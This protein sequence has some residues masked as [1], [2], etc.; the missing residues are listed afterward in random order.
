MVVVNDFGIGQ[1]SS[2]RRTP[3]GGSKTFI[4][5][6]TQNHALKRAHNLSLEPKVHRGIRLLPESEDPKTLELLG[7]N[8]NEFG[9]VISA[10]LSK[11]GNRRRDLFVRKLL[12]DC[13]FDRQSV[14]VKAGN[15]GRSVTHHA[16]TFHHEI[17]QDF[18]HRRTEVDRRVR[19]R[20]AVVKHKAWRGLSGLLKLVVNLFAIPNNLDRRFQRRQICLHRYRRFSVRQME[21]S[22][23][24]H[25]NLR[26]YLSSYYGRPAIAI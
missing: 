21:G 1:C 17:L 10:R 5:V 13:L 12:H 6:F 18:V 2:T 8:L 4:N 3:E 25:L 22:F 15:I 14:I 16:A 24:V 26:V 11:L 9:R 7:L 20:W 23:I 19:I